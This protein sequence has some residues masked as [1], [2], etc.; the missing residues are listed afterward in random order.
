MFK[1]TYCGAEAPSS[2]ECNCCYEHWS[3][4]TD[5]NFWRVALPVCIIGLVVLCAAL[6]MLP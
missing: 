4:V 5:A 1:C 2:R 6:A 3:D